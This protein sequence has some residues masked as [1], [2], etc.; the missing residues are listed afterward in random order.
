M[1]R[2]SVGES[3]NKE[4]ILGEVLRRRN[5]ITEDQ[6]QTALN[7]QK[8]KL[9]RRGQVVRLG[10]IIVELGYAT[11][12]DLVQAINEH[13]RLSV[14]SL[15]DNI[16]ERINK[17]RG[18]FAERLPSPRV[19][20]WLQLS[21]TTITVILLTTFVLSVVILSRQK[22]R[23]YMQ[24]V[25]VGTVSL[26]YFAEN[27]R[28]PLIEDDTLQLNTLI[29]NTADVEGLLYAVITDNGKVIKAHT[30]P[31]MIGK[32]FLKVDDVKK[33]KGSGDVTYFDYVLPGGRHTLNLTQSITF[34]DKQLGQVHVG[35]SI[36]FIEQATQKERTSV[37]LV[38]L[39]IF[40]FG[41]VTAL[42]L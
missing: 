26:K 9:I 10:H 35:V 12:K 23:L 31:N 21:L 39:V 30:N 3:S 18:T 2:K 16:K 14:E 5:I 13:Y 40:F 24:T 15:S 38:T 8:D 41:I 4:M 29:K 22:E 28:I 17:M 11:E 34:K 27:S 33:I 25:N 20:I 42:L 36:D 7:V 19:P 32:T 37:I 6:L 1:I